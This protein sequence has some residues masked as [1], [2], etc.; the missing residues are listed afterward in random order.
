MRRSVASPE[1]DTPSYWPVF[2]SA[3]H[4]VGRVAD[5]ALT[6]QPVCCSNG[7][8]QSTVLSSD[9]VLGVAGPDDVEGPSPSPTAVAAGMLGTLRPA[10]GLLDGV[11]ALAWLAAPLA[12]GSN[13]H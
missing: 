9:A 13:H 3:D 5:L 4:L 7:W 12:R 10:G 8:T 2:M 11:L 1:A 6:W